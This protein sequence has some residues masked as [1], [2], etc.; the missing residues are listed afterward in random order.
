ME[1]DGFKWGNQDQLALFRT[2]AYD[3]LCFHEKAEAVFE[4]CMRNE[5]EEY[6]AR[7]HPFNRGDPPLRRLDHGQLRPV[8]DHER[9][10]RHRLSHPLR[11]GRR[12][13]DRLAVRIVQQ[14]LQ[15]CSEFRL[16]PR[17][18]RLVDQAQ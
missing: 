18:P 12:A 4:F 10:R 17:G 3:D 5:L 15:P 8:R 11:G 7:D 16:E 2:A 9:R 1:V 14:G 6:D 13:R